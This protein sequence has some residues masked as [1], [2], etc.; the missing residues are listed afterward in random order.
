M[1]DGDFEILLQSID[2]S[3]G[4]IPTVPRLPRESLEQIMDAVN[5]MYHVRAYADVPIDEFA[6]DVCQALIDGKELPLEQQPK[7]RKR[8]IQVLNSPALSIAAKAVVLLG[9][10][11]H[12]FCEARIVTDARPVYGKD[13]TEPPDAMVMTHVLKIQFHGV[14]GSLDEI[15]IGLGSNDIKQLRNVLERAEE[16]ARSLQTVLERAGI[17]FI[18]PRMD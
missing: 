14:G 3:P 18:D 17:K 1:S 2:R 11:E 9:E 4:T 5:T 10:H 12:L 16:K 13:V 8:L 6:S 7:F 15:Y